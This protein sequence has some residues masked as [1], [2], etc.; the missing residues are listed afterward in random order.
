MIVFLGFVN[1]VDVMKIGVIV[2]L[3]NVKID[4][5]KD[6]MRMVVDKWGFI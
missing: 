5:F 2:I 4:M 1:V 6:M 3:R